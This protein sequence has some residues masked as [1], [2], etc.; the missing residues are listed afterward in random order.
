MQAEQYDTLLDQPVRR[1]VIEGTVPLIVRVPLKTEER[2]VLFNAP[3]SEYLPCLLRGLIGDF[4]SELEQSVS[5]VVFMVGEREVKWSLPIGVIF[6]AVHN[7]ALPMEVTLGIVCV[8]SK[9]PLTPS[10]KCRTR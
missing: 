2:F 4:V 3:R 8:C 10:S 9:A 7:G 1:R 6:D 5:A